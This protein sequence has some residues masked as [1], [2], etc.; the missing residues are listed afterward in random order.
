[1]FSLGVLLNRLLFSFQRLHRT[2]SNC[3][4]LVP[5]GTDS[6]LLLSGFQ[7]LVTLTLD[8]VIQHTIVHHPLSS[9]CTSNFIEIGKT[10]LR[11]D[12]LQGPLQVQGHV[13]QKLGQIAKIRPN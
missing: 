1:M 11:M 5:C 9:I 6:Q 12:Y 3:E 10:F 7:A 2:R 13:T 8:Y 4:K